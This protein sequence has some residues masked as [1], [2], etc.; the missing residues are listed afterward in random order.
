MTTSNVAAALRELE[1]AGYVERKRSTA[2]GRRIAVTLTDVGVSAVA[3][4]RALRA[5]SLREMV[6]VALTPAEQQ[7]LA[8][9]IPL[10]GKLAAAHPV[11]R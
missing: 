6:G 3:L 8:A 4:H 9:V 1:K 10:L 2:D 11:G 5:N 7:Q